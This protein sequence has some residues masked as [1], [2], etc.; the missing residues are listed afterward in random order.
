MNFVYSKFAKNLL[1]LETL[2]LGVLPMK[3]LL[4]IWEPNLSLQEKNTSLNTSK[5]FYNF[6]WNWFLANLKTNIL[7]FGYVS[8]ISMMIWYPKIF[9]NH[10][11]IPRLKMKVL[12]ILWHLKEIHQ[13]WNI[14]LK[15][16][17]SSLNFYIMFPKLKLHQIPKFK[18]QLR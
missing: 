16:L 4:P 18:F 17:G 7:F 1:K 15:N 11:N 6:T 2:I 5:I 9:S 13:W 10:S 3:M 14:F 12:P 8:G